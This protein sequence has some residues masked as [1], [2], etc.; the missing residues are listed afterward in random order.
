MM[1][2]LQGQKDEPA[3]TTQGGRPW[4][5]FLRIIKTLVVQEVPKH[6][7]AVLR[8]LA[9]L[10]CHFARIVNQGSQLFHLCAHS[11]ARVAASRR[12]YPMSS[13]ILEQY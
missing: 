11:G 1:R 7:H 2:Q 13:A 6:F 8:G 5:A 10:S 3:L 9:G 12:A 4:T